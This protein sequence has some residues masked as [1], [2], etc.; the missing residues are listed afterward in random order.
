MALG[1]DAENAGDAI[2]VL[3]KEAL[4][5]GNTA[6]VYHALCEFEVVHQ[7]EAMVDA[8]AAAFI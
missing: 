3:V 8:I 2:D 7:A 5:A 6:P 4:A 1:C